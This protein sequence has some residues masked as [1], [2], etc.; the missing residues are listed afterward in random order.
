MEALIGKCGAVSE[1]R[2]VLHTQR[3]PDDDGTLEEALQQGLS[4]Q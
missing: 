4:T 1:H 2:T 3:T